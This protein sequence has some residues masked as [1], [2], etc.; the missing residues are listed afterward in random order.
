MVPRSATRT[1]SHRRRAT[2]VRSFLRSRSATRPLTRLLD[3]A[4][5]QLDAGHAGT[6]GDRPQRAPTPVAV[7]GGSISLPVTKRNRRRDPALNLEQR[8]CFRRCVFPPRLHLAALVRL[9]RASAIFLADGLGH[10]RRER[11]S[12]TCRYAAVFRPGNGQSRGEALEDRGHPAVRIGSSPFQSGTGGSSATSLPLTP[13]FSHCLRACVGPRS[14]PP[15][16]F[17]P[18]TSVGAIRWRRLPTPRRRPTA[19]AH[20]L[21]KAC[22]LS[23]AAWWSCLAIEEVSDVRAAPP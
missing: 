9:R 18:P 2:T 6:W 21:A 11:V 23:A 17:E 19:P 10:R 1:T 12:P 15:C 20:L 16:F 8:C 22:P 3:D 14:G 7:S 4:S 13:S 5:T